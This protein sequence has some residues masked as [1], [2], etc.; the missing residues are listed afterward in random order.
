MRTTYVGVWSMCVCAA[1]A[2]VSTKLRIHLE[3]SIW[4]WC[5]V[6]YHCSG[7]S[8]KYLN[9][10][11]EMLNLYDSVCVCECVALC[12]RNVL[13]LSNHHHC[14]H[15]HSHHRHH[16]HWPCGFSSYTFLIVDVLVVVVFSVN[17]YLNAC[18]CGSICYAILSTRDVNWNMHDR[19]F[20]CVRRLLRMAVLRQTQLAHMS[21]STVRCVFAIL[22]VFSIKWRNLSSSSSSSSTLF[23][24]VA[25]VCGWYVCVCASCFMVTYNRQILRSWLLVQLR[26]F[27][28][29][30]KA[31]FQ[32]N[33][34]IQTTKLGDYSNK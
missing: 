27:R 23:S 9:K 33:A 13:V 3:H 31:R 18:G 25:V 4:L 2:C 28:Q 32:F 10:Q 11:F 5:C 34:T 16:H 7:V 17:A 12:T 1:A 29:Q 21:N 8:T 14:H 19:R 24:V 20:P 30:R 15:C 26:V 22:F 6:R